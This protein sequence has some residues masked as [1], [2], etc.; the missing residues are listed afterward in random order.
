MSVVK[1]QILQ[2]MLKLIAAGDGKL[3]GKTLDAFDGAVSKSTVY[4][5]LS[6]LCK[7]SVIEKQGAVYRLASTEYSFAYQ[8][9]GTLGED[10]I[11]ERDIAER[12][13]EKSVHISLLTCV[14]SVLVYL[15][16]LMMVQYSNGFLLEIQ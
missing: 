6:E 10:R 3:V 15:P 13:S 14:K 4:N 16:Q 9:N 1:E 11:F 2:Y 8:N 7:K 5:Y 12:L